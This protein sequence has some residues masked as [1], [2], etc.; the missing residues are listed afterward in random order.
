MS[1]S[2]RL[3]YT[4]LAPEAIAP[5]RRLEHYLNAECGL[6]AVLLELVRLRVSLLNGCD[7]CIGLHTHELRRHNEPPSR[8]EAVPVWRE[9][10]AFTKRERAGL[11]WAEVITNVQDGHAPDEEFAAVREHLDEKEVVD[12]TVA[13]ASINAWNRL[14]IAFRPQWNEARASGPKAG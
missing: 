5:L 7:F 14:G 12:L 4:E 11:R 10:D 2:Q 9:S 8:I 1:Q 3:R 13:I 6:E